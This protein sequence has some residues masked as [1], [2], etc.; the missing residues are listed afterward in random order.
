MCSMFIQA[1]KACSTRKRRTSSIFRYGCDGILRRLKFILRSTRSSATYAPIDAVRALR[2]TPPHL[3]PDFLVD[4]LCR[5][6]AQLSALPARPTTSSSEKQTN[7]S[8]GLLQNLLTNQHSKRNQLYKK[9]LTKSTNC[10]QN[11]PESRQRT[12]NI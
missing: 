9:L 11:R 1:L 3:V 8:S 6:S 4:L 2:G 5:V 10:A 12:S 7:S